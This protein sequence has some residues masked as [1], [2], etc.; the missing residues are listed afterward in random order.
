MQNKY[1]LVSGIIFGIV[2][3]LQ[4]VRALNQWAVQVGP[5]SVP[6]WFSWMA[7]VVT[8]GLCV[9]AFTSRRK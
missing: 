1:T 3:V 6:V 7:V 8:S 5:I 9:W 2:A 4:A